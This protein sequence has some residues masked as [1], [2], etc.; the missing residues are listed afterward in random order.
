LSKVISQRLLRRFRQPIEISKDRLQLLHQTCDKMRVGNLQG[1][2]EMI[3]QRSQRVRQLLV[4]HVIERH[5]EPR[6]FE[7]KP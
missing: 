1:V 7:S 6:N 3:S 4:F 5:S 2:D